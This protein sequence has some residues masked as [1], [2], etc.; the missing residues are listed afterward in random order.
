MERI[1]VIG[2]GRMG[3][4]IATRMAE[5]GFQV[6]GWTR[7]G[8]S[9]AR[10]A[11]LGITRADSLADLVAASDTL[12]LSLYDDTAVAAVLDA[13]LDL[14]V[15]GKLIV[16]TS[17]VSPQ[18]VISRSGAFAQNGAMILDAPISGG[19]ELVAA[20]QCGIF[21]GG[22]PEAAGRFEPTGAA[23]SDKLAHVG[24][25]GTGLAMKVVNNGLLQGY[26]ATLA[27]MVRI[28]KRAGLPLEVALPILA[29]GPAGTP[30]LNARLSKMLGQE[31]GVGFPVS[32]VAKDNEIF[33]Q[34][35][36]DMGVE[37]V[38]LAAAAV[39]WQ[40]GIDGGLAEEDVAMQIPFTYDQ[41]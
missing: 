41:A 1:G 32:G 37:P 20:G 25:L 22:S 27:E 7:S 24:P 31:D 16:E 12:I 38:T 21:V 14:E 23:L 9:Q 10:A 36:R 18:Q 33:Q 8:L 13:L 15:A 29:K 30:M 5:Q 35:A 4:A 34:V 26:F 3:S 11:E 28:A 39:L 6:T 40:S 19:P 17:T 2:L